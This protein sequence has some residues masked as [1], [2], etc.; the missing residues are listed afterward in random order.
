MAKGKLLKT[1]NTKYN[2]YESGIYKS[3][4][5]RKDFIK[6]SLDKGAA[7]EHKKD[8]KHYDKNCEL[9]IKANEYR[10]ISPDNSFYVIT[11]TEY[12]YGVYLSEL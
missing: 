11:K 12:D 10:L 1:L 5:T 2:Y 3:S 4:M 6:L 7:L 8:L 9:K